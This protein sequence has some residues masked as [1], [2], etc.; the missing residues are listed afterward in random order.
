MACQ[1]SA[2]GDTRESFS[3]QLLYSVGGVV[4]GRKCCGGTGTALCLA[5]GLK[6][7][8]RLAASGK[9]KVVISRRHSLSKCCWGSTERRGVK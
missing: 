3:G 7:E 5:G 4:I 2:N 9:M 8:I 6:K 1:R